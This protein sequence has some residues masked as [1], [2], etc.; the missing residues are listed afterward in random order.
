MVP[1]LNTLQLV[2]EKILVS[3]ELAEKHWQSLKR[4]NPHYPNAMTLYGEYLSIIRND[5]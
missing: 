4:I 3:A 1:D 5:A 2:G